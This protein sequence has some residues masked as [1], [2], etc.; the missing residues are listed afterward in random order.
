MYFQSSSY[1]EGTERQQKSHVTFGSP[2]K[3]LE[4]SDSKKSVKKN[5][6]F[7]GG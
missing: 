3:S 2:D 5:I 4:K 1:D 6:D 7:G